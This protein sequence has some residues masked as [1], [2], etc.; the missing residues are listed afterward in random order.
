MVKKEAMQAHVRRS[1]PRTAATLVAVILVIQWSSAVFAGPE[2]NFIKKGRDY[3]GLFQYDQ[4]R[5][6]FNKAI[7]LDPTSGE[8][9]FYL[10]L[11]LRKLNQSDAAMKAFERAHELDAE[12]TGCSKALA[13][14]YIQLA[15]DQKA[16]GKRGKTITFLSKACN[17]YP[18]NC[19]NWISLLELLQQDRKW[20]EIM[21]CGP[22]I[23]KA[24]R[25]ALDI[26][27][28]KD[29]QSALI[30]V[31]NAFKEQQDHVRAREYINLA[32]MIRQPNE[33]LLKLKQ[34]LTD[35]S[36]DVAS[37][38]LEKGRGLYEKKKPK[39]AL[40][41]LAK[42]QGADPGNQ[43]IN[44]LIDKIRHEVTLSDFT[45]TADKAEQKGDFDAAIESL[46]QALTFAEN[47]P[48]IT[49]RIASITDYIEKRDR[50]VLRKKA[51]DLADRQVAMEKKLKL[52]VILKNARESEKRGKFD[53][54]LINYKQALAIDADNA[55][56]K[57]AAEK[58]E[59]SAEDQKAR[60]EKFSE[61]IDKA[62]DLIKQDRHDE[63]YAILK[64][65]AE[66]PLNPQEKILPAFISTCLKLSNLDEA[67][68]L[69]KKL[70]ALQASSDESDETADAV[71][72]FTGTIAYLRGN[73]AAAR[74]PL[75]KIY[76]K[77]RN[78]SPELNGMI[79]GLRYDKYKWGLFLT[80]FFISIKLI[81]VGIELFGKLKKVR[82]EAAVERALSSGQYDKII[83]VLEAKLNDGSFI[84]NRK[85]LLLALA[86]AYLKKGRFQD[87]LQRA[88]EVIQKENR[89]A[90]AMRIMGEAYFQTG[91][92]ASD[93]IEKIYNLF[94]LDESRKELLTFLANHFR[95]IQADHKLAI[96]V[97]TKH[98][99][100]FPDD[101]ETVFYLAD[102]FLKR[103]S[104][105]AGNQ[106]VFE[107]ATRLNP[108]VPEYFQGSI[109]CLMQAGK[110]DEANRVLEKAQEKWPGS[111][112]F[113]RK[114]LATGPGSKL[115][116]G[117]GLGLSRPTTASLRTM[118]A[119][120]T[121]LPPLENETPATTPLPDDGGFVL[122][123]LSDSDPNGPGSELLPDLSPTLASAQAPTTHLSGAEGGA[124][125][126]PTL[127]P[128]PPL[129]P[130]Q[131]TASTNAVSDGMV[132]PSCGASNSQREYYCGTCGKPIR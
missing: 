53:Q 124:F 78:Y 110:G 79:W 47:D 68:S 103:Q 28:D 55:E 35:H 102:L 59:K 11:C 48:A 109:Q 56:I 108:D 132:C 42:A 113:Q 61:R 29:L 67:D 10:G 126:L 30:A 45:K 127:P 51:I 23:K 84:E 111:D 91:E 81:K 49:A 1:F 101:Q 122:P 66:E 88:N 70:A 26:G 86:E 120:P 50:A 52:D 37:N 83:P 119:L 89:N 64:E 25:D 5:E 96:E 40:D 95:S 116:R 16:A 104:F 115:P 76:D 87:A 106:R 75:N 27:D 62:E 2:Q 107:R 65:L 94:K 130:L 36:K 63:A 105:Q 72:Y 15:K 34:E 77:N 73:L 21:K 60:L 80:A 7:A 131:T 128:L 24:N 85:Q 69:T 22:V 58:A 98:F 99:S 41:A 9:Q 112:L 93:A 19:H 8:A 114:F 123:P 13:A 118:Q 18:Q 31:A 121:L 90:P 4:A 46:K 100:F 97:L 6:N 129:P 39:E 82:A 14:M 54:A 20:N 43:E 57:A 117:G 125:E 12:N 74:E 33:E 38:F 3:F 32:G 92:T 17:A 71:N 44:D